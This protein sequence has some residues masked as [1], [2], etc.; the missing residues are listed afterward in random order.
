MPAYQ[1]EATRR[2]DAPSS[3]VWDILTD[4]WT[5]HPAI[6]PK[7]A[8]VKL[9]VESGGKGAGTIIHVVMKVGLSRPHLRM[10]VMEPFPGR[11]LEEVDENSGAR[12]TFTLD[13]HEDD[14]T[15][16]TIQTK[17][18]GQKGIAGW[19][20]A[21]LTPGAASKLYAEELDNLDGY[22]KRMVARHKARRGE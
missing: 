8:F 7:R 19:L 6:L 13:E 10:H 18:P 9:E 3:V 1:A 5:H 20:A 2:I 12:T 11:V 21:K 4:Y 14:T 17:W 16:V 15:S 22:A